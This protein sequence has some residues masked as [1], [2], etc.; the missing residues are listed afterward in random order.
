[1]EIGKPVREE[2][3]EPARLVPGI[4][5]ADPAPQPEPVRVEP[6]KEPARNIASV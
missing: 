5:P 3:R 4:R 1:M 2:I 6:E